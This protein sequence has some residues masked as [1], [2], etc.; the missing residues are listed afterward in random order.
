MKICP[1]CKAENADDA[2]TCVC[3]KDLRE[4]L[5]EEKKREMIAQ[6]EQMMKAEASAGLPQHASNFTIQ[7]ERSLAPWSLGILGVVYLVVGI[8]GGICLAFFQPVVGIIVAIQALVVGLLVI[9]IAQIAEQ[10]NEVV[11]VLKR[12]ESL[13]M[14]LSEK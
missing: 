12:I 1:S 2:T 8:I 14:D 3:G 13:L 10:Q 11:M 4:V 9:V 5:T 6:A 7:K